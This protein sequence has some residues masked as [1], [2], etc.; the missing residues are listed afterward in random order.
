MRLDGPGLDGP[1]LGGRGRAVNALVPVQAEKSNVRVM[2]PDGVGGPGADGPAA[3][4]LEVELSE[5][6]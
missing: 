5:E 3:A 2:R 6:I 4:E 1:G